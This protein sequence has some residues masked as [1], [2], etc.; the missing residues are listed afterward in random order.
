MYF[1]ESVFR[2]SEM[3]LEFGSKK[4]IMN[5]NEAGISGTNNRSLLY[6]EVCDELTF[7]QPRIKR[8]KK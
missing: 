3:S 5:L 8:R 7:L 1:R 6:S 4:E 2:N